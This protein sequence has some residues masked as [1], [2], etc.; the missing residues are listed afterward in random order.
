MIT[1]GIDPSINS[2]GICVNKDNKKYKYYI[3]SN[4]KNFTKKILKEIQDNPPKDIIYYLY[5]K[6]V[7]EDYKTKERAK[8]DNFIQIS[9][10]IYKIL[11]KEKPD[12]IVMEGISYGSGSSSAL[13]DLAGLNYII[14]NSVYNYTKDHDKLH[15][16]PP[17]ELKSKACANGGATK[18]EM[19]Y[20]WLKCEKKMEQ[21][22]HLKIDD[23]ADAYFLSQII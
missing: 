3:I 5:D 6:N 21:Y 9:E 7:G 20:L 13:V 23:L 22:K 16:I 15:I 19:I 12:N 18:E 2:T 11:K 10:F 17:T 14:R 8:T 1:I 4:E